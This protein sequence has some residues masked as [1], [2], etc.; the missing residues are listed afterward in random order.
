M[1]LTKD[2]I[3]KWIAQE[4]DEDIHIDKF[5]SKYS[6]NPTSSVFYMSI[7]RLC[8][9]NF[10]KRVSRGWYRKIKYVEPVRWWDVNNS[11]IF[12]L[13]WPKSHE[14]DTTF[15]LE[16][17]VT[18]S[19]GDLIVVSGVSN[20]GKSSFVLNLLSENVDHH[21]CVLMGNEYT[22]LDGKAMAK[23]KRRMMKME[24]V[25]WLAD[26]KP[27]FDLLPVFDNYEDYIQSG[28]INMIDWINLEGDRLYMIGKVLESIKRKHGDGISVVAIQKEEQS[29]LG[30]GK[31]FT[32]DLADVYITIDLYGDYESRLTLGKVK[33]SKCKAMGRTW[34]FEIV[35]NGAKLF[36]IRELRK[37]PVCYGKSI[38]NFTNCERCGKKGYVD[39][40]D[41]PYGE[42]R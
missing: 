8:E 28:K 38:T 31:G 13:R 21:K 23:F 37:C 4:P 30:R 41:I 32:R 14:D 1:E 7:S 10:I 22:T 19:A 39:I 34:G 25:D 20:A 26:G 6:I 15:D 29:T 35:D 33:D 18:V 27:K 17:I 40:E 16:N 3:R 5:R 9:E 2:L 36:N 11:E 12:D 42:N 24:W